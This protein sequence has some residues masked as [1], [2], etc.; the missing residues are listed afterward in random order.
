VSK[1]KSKVPS[2]SDFFFLKYAVRG[3]KI[4]NFMVNSDPRELFR[5]KST[6]NKIISKNR[7]SFKK[8]RKYGFLGLT[9]FGTFF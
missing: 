3:I 4:Q 9:F 8:I 1:K 7:F 6:G 2:K 5:K